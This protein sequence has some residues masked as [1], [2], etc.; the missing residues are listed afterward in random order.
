M[1]Y[2]KGVIISN[3]YIESIIEELKDLLVKHSGLNG[4]MI[5]ES[6]H[7]LFGKID[8]NEDHD[9]EKLVDF[10]FFAATLYELKARFLNFN[11]KEIDWLDE[12]EVLKDR[13][14]AFTRL[15]QFKAFSEVGL[16]IASK[17]K[18][19]EKTVPVFKSYQVKDT[20]PAS[21]IIKNINL[22]QFESTAE[23][24][25]NRYN[26]VKGFSHI[27]KDLPDIQTSIENFIKHVNLD[28]HETFEDIISH[29]NYK[30]AVAYFLALLET[31]RWGIVRAEQTK[32]DGTI[33]II[34]NE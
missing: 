34:K 4:E 26:T 12:V 1:N 18:N 30:D 27:D 3:K 21:I 6:L 28:I 2:C 19:E 23:E 11:D 7:S 15:L 13:D 16:A 31:V 29:G 8:R 5:E 24:A 20:I 22:T 9:I 14:I 32:F 25:Y 33:T 10:V 17:I